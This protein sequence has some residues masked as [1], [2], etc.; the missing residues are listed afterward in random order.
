M[1]VVNTTVF[2]ISVTV[3]ADED[4]EPEDAVAVVTDDLVV[5]LVPPACCGRGQILIL[6]LLLSNNR[7][8]SGSVLNGGRMKR[9]LFVGGV[10]TGFVDTIDGAAI[11]GT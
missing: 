2:G 7:T 5:V 4:D 11:A 3:A 8:E 9:M 6:G 1:F 10:S